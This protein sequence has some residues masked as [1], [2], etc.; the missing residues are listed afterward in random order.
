MVLKVDHEKNGKLYSSTIFGETIK[1]FDDWRSWCAHRNSSILW[2]YKETSVRKREWKAWRVADEKKVLSWEWY[3]VKLACRSMA[4]QLKGRNR[5]RAPILNCKSGSKASAEKV[6]EET[7]Y[8]FKEIRK[9]KQRESTKE[10]TKGS[11][12]W[13]EGFEPTGQETQS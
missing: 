13:A 1:K 8:K 3:K 10:S 12:S 7:K 11:L 9:I 4:Q 2:S 5:S 6:N